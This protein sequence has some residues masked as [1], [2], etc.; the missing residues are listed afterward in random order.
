MIISR[1][2]LRLSFAGGGSDLPAYYRDEPGAVTSAAISKF[3][4]ITVNRKFDERIR[5]SYSVT[6]TVDRAADLRHDLIR[7]SM[8]LVGLDRG[9]EISSIS[10]IPSEGTGLGSSSAYTVGLLNAFHAYL[11]REAPPER[12]ATEACLVEINR[13]AKPIGKQDQYISAYGGFQHFRFLCDGSVKV[14]PIHCTEEV[15]SGLQD[16]LLLLYTGLTRS[17][18]DILREQL[19]NT[20]TQRSARSALRRM[21][22]LSASMRDALEAGDLDAFG[23]ILHEGWMAKRQLAAGISS[24]AIDEWYSTARVH[25][26]LGGKIAGAGGGGFLLL[27]APVTRHAEIIAAL[28]GLRRML[29][30]FE[31]VGSRIVYAEEDGRWA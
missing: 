12:L 2:P 3:I 27:Y 7:E 26:A 23:E 15:I 29:F 10:D 30:R 28:P 6:E 16:Q 13:C 14:S 25:G 9:L 18:G 24:P 8:G 1:T 5:A 21:V 19:H 11:G 31:P 20:E 17:S 4:Y 22:E